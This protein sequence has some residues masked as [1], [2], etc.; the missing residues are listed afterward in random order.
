MNIPSGNLLQ[1]L[2]P[3]KNVVHTRYFTTKKEDS[4]NIGHPKTGWPIKIL[5]KSISPYELIKIDV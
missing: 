4:I 3:W 2:S 1:Y 5:S